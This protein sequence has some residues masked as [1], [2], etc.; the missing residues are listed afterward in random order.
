[1][2][3]ITLPILKTILLSFGHD[4]VQ[5]L[6]LNSSNPKTLHIVL[7]RTDVDWR[8]PIIKHLKEFESVFGKTEFGNTSKKTHNPNCDYIEIGKYKIFASTKERKTIAV[9]AG[10]TNELVLY[11]TIREYLNQYETLNLK[12][13][14]GSRMFLVS[15]VTDAIHV[16]HDT[17]GRRKADV[18]LLGAFSGAYSL[19]IKEPKFVAWE[20]VETYWKDKSN[21]LDYALA[22]FPSKVDLHKTGNEYVLSPSI[23]VKCNLNEAKDVIFG[24]D[25]LGKGLVLSQSWKSGHFDWDE[26]SK[27]LSLV[28]DDIIHAMSDVDSKMWPH[29]QLRNHGGHSSKFLPGIA[30]NAVPFQD[31]SSNNLILPDIARTY[32]QKKTA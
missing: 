28:C 22:T 30:A 20:A 16:A 29:F 25:I 17:A 15:D 23:S 24:T 11:N 2:A 10:K 32:I 12:F 7:K 9:K 1:M 13:H 31:L 4:R 21:V 26:R 18:N 27:T 19:S 8:T 14:T 6:P 3:D 5:T